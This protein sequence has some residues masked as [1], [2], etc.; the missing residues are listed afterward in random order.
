MA[1]PTKTDQ[2]K[3]VSLRGI[4]KDSGVSRDTFLQALDEHPDWQDMKL[5]GGRPTKNSPIGEFRLSVA[6]QDAG[7]AATSFLRAL[8]VIQYNEAEVDQVRFGSLNREY[9]VGISRD[10]SLLSINE[11]TR[12]IRAKNKMAKPLVRA[13]VTGEDTPPEVMLEVGLPGDLWTEADIGRGGEP[14]RRLLPFW[15]MAVKRVGW[16]ETGFC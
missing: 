12:M 9:I 5:K 1:E 14:G 11:A 13:I 3:S 15:R 4:A 8:D 2:N 7:V 16:P 6:S 10:D